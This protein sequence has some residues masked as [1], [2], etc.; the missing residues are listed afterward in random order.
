MDES[1]ILV[2]L[3]PTPFLCSTAVCPNWNP[4]HLRLIIVINRVPVIFS[5]Q[6]SSDSLDPTSIQFCRALI[7]FQGVASLMLTLA[8]QAILLLRGTWYILNM[9]KFDEHLFFFPSRSTLSEEVASSACSPRS[10]YWRDHLDD[11]RN[12]HCDAR[13]SVRRSLCC[14]LYSN[15]VFH[16]MFVSTLK[17]STF[18]WPQHP[19]NPIHV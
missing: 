1:E 19:T 12:R 13:N 11:H 10:V 9:R 16:H 2:R 3:P 5:L 18:I 15:K 14:N 6:P 17:A 8:V 7:G 4:W